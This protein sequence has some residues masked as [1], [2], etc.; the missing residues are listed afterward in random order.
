MFFIIL[1]LMQI[2]SMCFAVIV[3]LQDYF[4]KFMRWIL[5]WQSLP[6]YYW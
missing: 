2:K 1:S 3:N 5:K 6:S 4:I